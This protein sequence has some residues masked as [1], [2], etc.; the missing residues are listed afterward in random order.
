M[1]AESATRRNSDN[2][3]DQGDSCARVRVGV[4]AHHRND[5]FFKG[6]PMLLDFHPTASETA[7]GQEIG[8]HRDRREQLV[9]VVAASLAVLIVAAIAVLM[10]V[11]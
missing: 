8:G 10:G 3:V 11:A 2:L 4:L 1:S 7:D 5:A 9:T 6:A